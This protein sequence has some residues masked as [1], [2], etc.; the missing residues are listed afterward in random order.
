M[1]PTAL[2]MDVTSEDRTFRLVYVAGVALSGLSPL[3][4]IFFGLSVV[5]MILLFPA[6]NGVVGLPITAALLLWAVNDR[7]TMGEHTNGWALNVM[8][9]VLVLL[10]LYLAV[11]SAEGVFSAILGGGL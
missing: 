10:A 1:I 9:S 2:G 11:T 8:N 4:S 3:V 7:Q 5:D 6:Y